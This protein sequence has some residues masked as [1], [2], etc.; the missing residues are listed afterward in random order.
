VTEEPDTSQDVEDIG[1]LAKL[2]LK[3]TI[4]PDQKIMVT[5]VTNHKNMK[6]S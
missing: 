2:I 1:K 4:T 3:H 6:R 5:N